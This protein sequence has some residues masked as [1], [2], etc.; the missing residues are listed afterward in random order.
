M[1]I[2]KSLLLVACGLSTLMAF[3]QNEPSSFD[4][5]KEGG[6][7]VF[8]PHWQLQLQIGAAH[9]V[10]EAGFTDLL[11]PAAAL[12]AGYQFTPLWGLRAG[13]SG[14]QGRGVWVSP[15]N[16]YKFNYLQ[17][18][19]DALLDL[20]NLF[21]GY[22]H[23]RFFNAYLFLGA[24]V[25]GAFGNDEAVAL[26]DAGY[27]MEYLWRDNKVSLAGRGGIGANLRL[28]TRVYFNLE[29][30]ANLLTDKFNSKK[31]GNADWQFNA[32]AGFTIKLGKTTKKIAPVRR[33]VVSTPLPAETKPVEEPVAIV[34]EEK[35]EEKQAEAQSMKQ[36]IF[37][38]INSAV[39]RSSEESKIAR[40]VSFLQEN[41]NTAVVVCG[42]ADAATGTA[43]VNERLSRKRAQG[44]AD[45]LKAAGIAPDRIKT[46]FK[47][48]KEQPFSVVEENRVTI[49][50]AE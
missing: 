36:N 2:K 27:Q 49:C 10:G 11:S 6:K 39:I 4:K 46:D 20:S 22:N 25:N 34:A 7:T 14:W 30:N 18:N 45:A 32:L 15:L 43:T 38:T 8:N 44:V 33:E 31:A 42:Y 24:G 19:V 35:K 9:T 21:C 13:V 37:F 1:N 40:L 50:I 12:S 41:P 26:N 3:G 23:K 29:V 5:T 16:K 17:G 28:A 48:D 47:G